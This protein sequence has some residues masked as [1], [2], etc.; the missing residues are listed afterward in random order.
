[1][2]EEKKDERRKKI[3]KRESTRTLSFRTWMRV[4]EVAEP[5]LLRCNSERVKS[6]TQVEGED[7][8]GGRN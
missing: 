4:A 7:T 3:T 5:L 8:G 1:M 6:S 2:N